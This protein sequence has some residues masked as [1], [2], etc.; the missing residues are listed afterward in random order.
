MAFF[1]VVFFLREREEGRRGEEERERDRLPAAHSPPPTRNGT[2]HLDIC[3]DC[4]WNKELPGQG[5]A[6]QS[7][8]SHRPRL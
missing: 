7:T 5:M 6:L 3:P 2:H 1:R 8:K 4:E